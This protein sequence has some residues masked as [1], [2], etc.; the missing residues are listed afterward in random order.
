VCGCVEYK[1]TRN[2]FLANPSLGSFVSLCISGLT[3]A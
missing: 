3:L 2:L 1:V